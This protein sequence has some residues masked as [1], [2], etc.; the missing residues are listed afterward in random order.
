[1]SVAALKW[2]IDLRGI[3]GREKAVLLVLAWHCHSKTQRCNPSTRTIAA[4]VG[5][6]RNTVSLALDELHRSGLIEASPSRRRDATT[7]YTLNL[8]AD[9][10][11]PER[12]STG[13][14]RRMAQPVSH[15]CGSTGEP[16]RGSA[17]T[18]GVAQPVSQKGRK[19]PSE[20]GKSKKPCEPDRIKLRIAGGRD[21]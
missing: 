7:R 10:I 5:L 13:R 17:C 18:H 4:E 12:G 9:L 14:P 20:E 2:A 21:A 8:D 15:E 1:M 3:G 11:E 16:R 6:S 19:N